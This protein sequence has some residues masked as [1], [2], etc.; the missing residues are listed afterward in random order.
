MAN[1][2][3]TKK[4]ISDSG[5]LHLCDPETGVLLY[6]DEAETKPLTIEIHSK[7][8]KAYRNALSTLLRKSSARKGKA[9]F[10]NNVEDNN[11]LLSQICIKANNFD[12]GTGAIDS[13]A[14]F[15]E[16]F[17]E[18]GLYWIKDAVSQFLEENASFL[19]K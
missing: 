16:L 12:M 13:P 10:E 6:A 5:V 2:N 11:V 3:I 8:S 15:L 7:A 19:Q 17:N 4:V 14:K 1:F 9:T 18:A